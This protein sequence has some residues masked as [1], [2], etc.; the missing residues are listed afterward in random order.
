MSLSGEEQRAPMSL[1][2]EEQPPRVSRCAAA[3]IVVLGL[4]VTGAVLGAVWAWLAPPVHTIVALTRSGERVD[5]YLGK[6]ADHLF[7]AAAMMIG[8]LTML[9]VVSAVLVWQW[10][11]HRGPVI[12]AALWIGQVA[13]AAAARVS[14]RPL[15]IGATARS[16]TRRYR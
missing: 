4:A 16:T 11:P 15:P 7:V 12:A 5:A 6:E 9:A 8:L 10:R 1:S 3:G 2:G 14:V 13:A